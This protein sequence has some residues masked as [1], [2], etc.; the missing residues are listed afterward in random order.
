MFEEDGFNRK[1]LV[2][3]G[4]QYIPAAL[5]VIKQPF[6]LSFALKLCIVNFL[7]TKD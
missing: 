1:I 3:H 2:L 5:K 7:V 6:I 4:Y